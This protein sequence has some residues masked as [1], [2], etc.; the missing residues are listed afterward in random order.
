[1]S[2]QD[3]LFKSIEILVEKYLDR[4][5]YSRTV[6]STVLEV[7]GDKFKCSIDGAD[8][9]IKNGC[10]VTLTRGT[11]VWEHIPQNKII[12]AFIMGTR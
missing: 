5:Q 1:M 8:Y 10:G 7:S 11:A 12:N 9:L 4:R 2:I 6:A 3:E